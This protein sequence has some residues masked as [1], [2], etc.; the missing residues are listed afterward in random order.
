MR[1]TDDG[2]ALLERI[3][4]SLNLLFRP[5]IQG[6]GGFIQYQDR[7]VA[8]K[9]PGNGYACFLTTRKKLATFAARGIVA[10]G[11]LNDE[12]VSIGM[13]GR[14][15]DLLLG[16]ILFAKTNVDANWQVKENDVF[17][18]RVRQSGVV[19]IRTTD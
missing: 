11:H 12:V 3:D 8:D 10:F 17:G 14:L 13:F 7:S 9:S 4:G 15:L 6:R 18:V 2:S 19:S 16:W 1:D 5:R